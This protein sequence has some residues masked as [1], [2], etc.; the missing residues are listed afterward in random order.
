MCGHPNLFAK[1]AGI[2]KDHGAP[3]PD[4]LPNDKGAA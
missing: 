3:A 1:L 4:I 2:L